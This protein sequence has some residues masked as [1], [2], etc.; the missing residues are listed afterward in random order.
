MTPEE[1]AQ[2]LEID[3]NT[4]IIWRVYP[5]FPTDPI[6]VEYDMNKPLYVFIDNS[7]WGN[8]PNAIIVMQPE[9][10][11]FNIIDAIEVYQPPKKCAEFLVC[12]P[13]FQMTQP[14]EEFLQ[15]YKYCNRQQAI[16]ISDPYDTKSA[17]WNSTILDD[18]RSVWINLMLP[19]DRDKK[20]QILKTRTNMYRIRYNE[21]CLDFASAILNAKYPERK[22][23]S[24]STTANDKPVHN[25]TS[26]Y[27]SALEYGICYILEHPT[28]WQDKSRVTP[29]TRPKR[30]ATGKLIK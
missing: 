1:I 19:E 3:Y 12:Q 17:L 2:E 7:H 28:P 11:Y 30:D 5:E 29:D 9:A 22:E 15:R 25:W 14:Q 6:N 10:H 27:R 4:A 16:F 13:K 20:S 21:N 26:H 23:D 18:Y 8:D 24:N